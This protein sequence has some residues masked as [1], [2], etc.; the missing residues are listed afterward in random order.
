MAR[1]GKAHGFGYHPILDRVSDQSPLLK[2]IK[3]KKKPASSPEFADRVYSFKKWVYY[4]FPEIFV[5]Q[6]PPHQQE[7]I[8]LEEEARDVRG[9]RE[10]ITAFRGSS[11]S[12]IKAVLVPLYRIVNQLETYVVWVGSTD[13]QA[14]S[15]RQSVMDYLENNYKLRRDYGNLVPNLKDNKPWSKKKAETITGIF[16]ESYGVGSI[17]RGLL[18]GSIR[19]SLIIM[20]DVNSDKNQCTPLQRQKLLQIIDD[21]ILRLGKP[22]G[23]CNYFGVST[24]Q[25]SEGIEAKIKARGS[26]KYREYPGVLSEG[27]NRELWGK[28]R[29]IYLD[30]RHGE[31]RKDLALAFYL[32]NKKAMDEGAKVAWPDMATYYDYYIERTE[33][34]GS[35]AK[36]IGLPMPIGL[37][38]LD[39]E[40]QKLPVETCSL[41]RVKNNKI[42]ITR[43]PYEGDIVDLDECIDYG[44]L[45]PAVGETEEADYSA[46]ARVSV[47]K[48]GRQFC[49]E[50]YCKVGDKGQYLRAYVEM[51]KQRPFIMCGFESNGFQR[52]LRDEWENIEATE[53]KLGVKMPIYNVKHVG[54]KLPRMISALQTPMVNHHLAINEYIVYS[55]P[56]V[57]TQFINLGSSDHDD[58]PDALSSCM[59]MAAKYG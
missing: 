16:L 18:R 35:F 57:W 51:H 39:P 3:D 22:D 1:K 38:P 47:D 13:E 49:T 4:Y 48:F 8:D 30:L 31:A 33:K 45:D 17:P 36:E 19:P 41:F 43:G 5:Y 21:V 44:F 12:T 20:D 15:R 59:I 42:H 34:P 14:Y 55:K 26:W 40:R 29:L 32:Q 2:L 50:I 10:W 37:T 52:Y 53:Y 23:S 6:S 7:W 9:R 24:P 25:H 28:W 11:K 56:E 46:I 58:A 27:K 54:Q